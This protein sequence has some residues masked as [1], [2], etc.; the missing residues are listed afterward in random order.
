MRNWCRSPTISAHGPAARAPLCSAPDL[1]LTDQTG[2]LKCLFAGAEGIRTTGPL[3]CPAFDSI[4]AR[5]VINMR[6]DPDR[7]RAVMTAVGFADVRIVEV[8]NDYLVDPALLEIPIVCSVSARRACRRSVEESR[9]GPAV[10]R[11]SLVERRE[12]EPPV[13]F[14]VPGGLR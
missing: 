1:V 7:C 12:F 9:T 14:V 13:L 4:R 3:S 6:R 2:G 8:T 11:A 10:R 5:S